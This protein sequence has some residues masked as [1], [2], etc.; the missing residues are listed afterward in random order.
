MLFE[1]R[2]LIPIPETSRGCRGKNVFYLN[3]IIFFS[4]KTLSLVKPTP[5]NYSF[6]N[7]IQHQPFLLYSSS[8][9]LTV[10][11]FLCLSM[12]STQL[13]IIY[14][15]STYH[16][17]LIFYYFNQTLSSFLCYNIGKVKKLYNNSAYFALNFF[18]TDIDPSWM[19]KCIINCHAC[20][21]KYHVFRFSDSAFLGLIFN[22]SVLTV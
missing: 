1:Y 19:Q 8:I 18:N 7:R 12:E 21:A 5:I 9:N 16:S 10:E 15:S 2:F 3:F 6:P 13:S 11:S 20:I 4:I 17:L 22:V 14:N